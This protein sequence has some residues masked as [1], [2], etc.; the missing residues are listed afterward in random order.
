MAMPQREERECTK[1]CRASEAAGNAFPC[2]KVLLFCGSV[3]SLET[4]VAAAKKSEGAHAISQQT[5]VRLGVES[6]E[7]A[8]TGH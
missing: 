2:S 3:T 8:D 7:K 4:C 5:S 6:H 1:Q